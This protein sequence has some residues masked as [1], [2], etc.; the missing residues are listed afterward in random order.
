MKKIF[1]L[2]ALL[3]LT[4]TTAQAQ[5]ASPKTI[6][7]ALQR[8]APA[9]I[10]NTEARDMSKAPQKKAMDLKTGEHMMGY[11][12]TD[13]LPES[14]YTYD[15]Y[16]GLT[17]YV[18][19]NYRAGTVFETQVTER[20]IGGK[21]TKFR[22]AIGDDI[23]PIK[24]YFV[25]E[26]RNNYD[27]LVG[28]DPWEEVVY[29]EPIMPNHGWNEVTLQNPLEIKENRY[30]ILG[31]IYDQTSENYP[32]VTDRELDT[33]YTSQYGFFV[34]GYLASTYGLDWYYFEE[35]QLCIQAVVSGGDFG[36][37]DISLRN[38]KL[39]SFAQQG[40]E[41]NYS[42][43]MTNYGMEEVDSYTLNVEID[44]EVVE[45]IDTPAPLSGSATTYSGSTTLPSSIVAGTAYHTLKVY[46]ATINGSAPTEY[47]D[48]D[49]LEGTFRVYSESVKRQKHLIEQLTSVQC[50]NCPKGYAMI[51]YMQ[52]QHPRKYAWAALHSSGM[53]TDPYY[54]DYV[55]YPEYFYGYLT[56]NYSWGWPSGIFDR[57]YL[58]EPSLD[59]S[60]SVGL[61]FGWYESQN[62]LAAELIDAAIDRQY[63][64][65]PAFVSVDITPEYNEEAGTLAIT[66]AGEGVEFAK[67]IL[68]DNVLN[69]YII[70]DGLTGY[71]L[72]SDD[73]E[74]PHRNTLRAV[75]SS[76]YGD[77]ITWTSDNTYSNSYLME[78]NS[79]WVP[80]NIRIIA[81]ICGPMVT[82]RG[83]TANWADPYNA[84]V[85]NCNEVLL[86]GTVVGV[87]NPVVDVNAT[88]STHYTID[89]RQ[90][91]APT[92]GLNIVKMSDGTVKK[93]LI[94]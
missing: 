48:D 41:V 78:F 31:F 28:Y 26:V 38:F 75:A 42:F 74:F 51:E 62:E 86:D 71:Q 83:S 80:D 7:G 53:G 35:G 64:S 17:Y 6:D 20:F 60:G 72:G 18:G 32:L 61:I 36:N 50:V 25:C 22:Y 90:L 84:Y 91:T 85:N 9:P 76:I 10:I 27:L 44:G 4:L 81:F 69:V 30:Y 55:S 63:A 79:S 13:D 77:N 94:K 47:T 73:P 8:K 29:A 65:I 12:I 5:E 88:E 56:Y 37:Y 66:V 92:K 43:I 40:G 46:V 59:T 3:A 2:L 87:S 70:E 58:D 89:G 1:T 19:T 24:G 68:S 23:T 16:L 67:D 11:Y 45:T 15:G 34:Y 93:V 49:T 14:M 52:E 39:D 82:W 21:I 57:M 33:D 54:L